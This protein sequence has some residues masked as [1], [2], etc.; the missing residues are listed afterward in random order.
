MGAAE[1][2]DR[3]EL[4]ALVEALR[5]NEYGLAI[6]GLKDFLATHPHHE[7]ATGL[8]AAAYFQTG[9]REQARTLYEQLLARYPGNAL[10]RFQLGIL[11][12]TDAPRE[13]LAVLSPLLEV[14]EDFMAHFHSALAHLQLGEPHA[15]GPLLDRAARYM[16]PGHPLRE[17]LERLRA[18][19]RGSG[20]T[21]GYWQ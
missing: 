12:L 6:V 13:A 10:A 3:A 7:I 5:R 2:P 19:L 16:P 11:R 1:Q 14:E 9:M 15:A 4:A 18:G 17:Q 8:L 20:D 21:P